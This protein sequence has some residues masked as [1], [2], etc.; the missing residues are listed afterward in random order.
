MM[1][2][3]LIAAAMG[4]AMFAGTAL[5]QNKPPSSSANSTASAKWMT[6]A[7]PGQWRGSQL[8]GLGVYNNNNEKIGDINELIVDRAGKIDAVVIGVGGFLGIGEHD[9]AVPFNELK[10]VDQPAV[11][12]STNTRG[13]SD[14]GSGTATAT[15]TTTGAAT[16]T[17]TPAPRSNMNNDGSNRGSNRAAVENTNTADRSNRLYPDHAVLNMTKDQLKA[18]PEFKYER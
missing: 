6:H 5:A 7:Q 15:N 11:K 18:A 4:A 1:A 16:G 10:W 9:V 12:A 3:C 17:A 14:G 13:G 2:K 8:K